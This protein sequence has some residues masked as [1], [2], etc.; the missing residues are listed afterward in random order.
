M[1]H[2]IMALKKVAPKKTTIIITAWHFF[3]TNHD[4]PSR[5]RNLSG[6]P[7]ETINPVVK[8]V[9]WFSEANF[10]NSHGYSSTPMV[11]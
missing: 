5:I 3:G 8:L 4:E 10:A 1:N 6:N 9:D 7:V 11:Q 2:H